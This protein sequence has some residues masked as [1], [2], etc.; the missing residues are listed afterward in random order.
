MIKL[1]LS[2]SH[3]FLFVITFLFVLSLAQLGNSPRA[4][5]A[6]ETASADY[7]DSYYSKMLEADNFYKQGDLQTAKQIQQEVKPEF[8]P[9]EAVPSA[10]GV[11]QLD[12]TEQQQWANIQQA[13]AED[14][15]EEEAIDRRIF[16]PLETLTENNPQFVSGLVL[17][18]DTY[19]LYGYEDEAI[20]TIES[21]AERYP[22]RDDVLDKRIELLLVDGK[23]LEASIA[24]REF[25]MSYPDFHKTPAY[26]SAADQYFQQYQEKLKSKLTTSGVI[27][28][29]G[30]AAAGDSEAG[31]S[32]G[33]TLIDGNESEVGLALAN[34]HKSEVQ[35]VTDSTQQ[36]YINKV[37][38]KLSQF[39]GRND[40]TYEFNIVDDPS[41]N[42][43]ALPGGKLFFNTGLLQLMD[44]E[45]ELAGIMGHEMAH[46]VLSHGYKQLG[47]SAISSASS[48]VLSD[49]LGDDVGDIATIG[50]GLLNKKFS[51]DKEKQAD[52]LGIRVLAAAGYSA[53]GLYNVMAKLD[54]LDGESGL[55]DSLLSTHPASE[56]RM[57]YLEELIQIKGYNRYGFEGVAEYQAVFPQ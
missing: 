34:N 27:G 2:R 50:S 22:G 41:P 23:P 48:N 17:L 15:Q 29:V 56:E 32:I 57:R 20:D 30:Q 18:A 44:S 36:A 55:G 26:S 45:A 6:Q 28:G 49:L 37:G 21:A 16:V 46:S 25:A 52:V 39:M 35:M 7:G 10:E 54:R 14:P 38:Q 31:L 40:F 43:S 53:D 3:K 8:P 24:A 9:P 51:R 5:L 1:Y 47:E 19:D 12:A 13:I 4:I 42:A 33:K 11:E